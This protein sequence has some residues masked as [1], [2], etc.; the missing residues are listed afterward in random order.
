MSAPPLRKDV[1]KQDTWNLNLMF[2]NVKAWEEA[3][4]KLQDDLANFDKYRGKL[5]K[6]ARKI[7]QCYDVSHNFSQMLEKVSAFAQL[8][9]WQG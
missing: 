4:E 1:D 5:G 7:R 3:F 2:R 8:K 6:S 9:Y